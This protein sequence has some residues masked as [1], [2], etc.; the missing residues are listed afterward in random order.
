MRITLV[1]VLITLVLT[2]PILSIAF[3][4]SEDKM[5]LSSVDSDQEEDSEEEE[6]KEKDSKKDKIEEAE[7]SNLHCTSLTSL[8]L[9]S[10]VDHHQKYTSEFKLGII[11]PPPEQV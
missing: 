7:T 10:D 6:S 9:K 2:K 8:L 4:N 5:E 11:L 3:E 1:L